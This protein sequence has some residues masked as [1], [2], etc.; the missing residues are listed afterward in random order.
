MELTKKVLP[1]LSIMLLITGVL[2]RVLLKN[3]PRALIGDYSKGQYGK[4]PSGSIRM[5][6][7]HPEPMTEL[8]MSFSD[9]D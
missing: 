7:S 4:Y 3:K 2:R 5:E 1:K 9:L 8:L 6:I